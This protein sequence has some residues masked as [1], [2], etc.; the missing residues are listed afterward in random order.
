MKHEFVVNLTLPITAKQAAQLMTGR[1]R[2]VFR[3]IDPHSK[4]VLETG[5][6][7]NVCHLPGS[8]A[9]TNLDCKGSPLVEA[10]AEPEIEIVTD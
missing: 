3:K 5:I 8:L 9:L 1:P 6:G 4:D 10:V 2:M 7:C